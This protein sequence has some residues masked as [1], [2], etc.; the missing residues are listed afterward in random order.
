MPP[1]IA[2]IARD[3]EARLQLAHHVISIFHGHW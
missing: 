3:F 1:A 2:L